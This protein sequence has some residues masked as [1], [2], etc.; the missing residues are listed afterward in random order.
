MVKLEGKLLMFPEH[1]VIVASDKIELMRIFNEQEVCGN[2]IP[3]RVCII[4]T[5]S[6]NY[7]VSVDIQCNSNEEAI[8]LWEK[9]MILIG[10]V[11]N[12]EVH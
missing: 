1:H 9:I 5:L 7:S 4:S 8:E 2:F 6:L 3:A 10:K 11:S 12:M